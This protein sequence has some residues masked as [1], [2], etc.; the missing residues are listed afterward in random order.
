MCL[1]TDTAPPL[2]D[3]NTVIRTD[4]KWQTAATDYARLKAEADAADEKLDAALESGECGLRDGAG[5][6]RCLSR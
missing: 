3:R 5:V 4:A 1:D 6:G 2:T